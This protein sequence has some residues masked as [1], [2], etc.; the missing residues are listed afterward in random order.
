M[1]N[2]KDGTGK[3]LRR[4]HDTAQQHLH[5][6]KSMGC[7]PDGSFITSMLELKS[8]AQTMFEW[9]QYSSES[10]D[11]P[12]YQTLLDFVN[13]RAQAYEIAMTDVGKRSSKNETP[14]K[15]ANPVASFAANADSKSVNCIACKERH[16]LFLCLKFKAMTH[17]EKWA[18][19]KSSNLCLNYLKPG[20]IVQEL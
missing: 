5:A 20:H 16:P 3:E 2:L 11:V 7:E 8:D 17:E 9:Q 13:L 1:P 19:L 12:P 4:L 18:I 6:L 14:M 10:A 15:K